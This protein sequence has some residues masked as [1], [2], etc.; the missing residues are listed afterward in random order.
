MTRAQRGVSAACGR[1]SHRA[2]RLRRSRRRAADNARG[3]RAGA[4]AADGRRGAVWR[5]A[6][7]PR[8]HVGASHRRVQRRGSDVSRHLLRSRMR[9]R[10]TGA[11]A[12]RAAPVMST[13]P[14]RGE[15]LDQPLRGRPADDD[16]RDERRTLPVRRGPLVQ[17]RV[18]Q[19]RDHHRVRGA[20]VR[21]GRGARG[22]RIPCRHAGGYRVCVQRCGARRDPPRA[23]RR[24]DGGSWR[25]A[26]RALLR[27]GGRDAAVRHAR[28]CLSRANRGPRVHAIPLAA[29]RA[30]A[31]LDA[32]LRRPGWRRLHRVCPAQ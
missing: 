26:V 30:R 10:G 28:R 24:R 16:H 1:R 14:T 11:S 4:G 7:S 20:L 8:N 2:P 12:A 23:P 13:R 15:R 21:S 18:R 22:A 6:G 25:G 29:H 31:R 19:G 9:G 27:L 5:A 3:V 17:H 32:R